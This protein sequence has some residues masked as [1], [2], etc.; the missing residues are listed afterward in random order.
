MEKIEEQILQA[1]DTIVQKRISELQFDKTLKARII[2][3]VDSSGGQYRVGYQDSIL[4]AYSNNALV[5]YDDNT[6]VEI[7]VPLG[8]LSNKKMILRSIDA[9]DYTKGTLTL[10]QYQ[11]IALMAAAKAQETADGQITAFYEETAPDVSAASFGD[12]WIDTLNPPIKYNDYDRIHRLQ[13]IVGGSQGDLDWRDASGS[14]IGQIYLQAYNAQSTADGK[15]KTYYETDP[16]E[17]SAPSLGD[18]WVDVDDKNKLYRYDGTEWIIVQDQSIEESFSL[19]AV[20]DYYYP[21]SIDNVTYLSKFMLKKQ[22]E[23]IVSER[24]EIRAHPFY[25]NLSIAEL[26]SDYESAAFSVLGDVSGDAS[27][28]V[29]GQVGGVDYL[30][31]SYENNLLDVTS[32]VGQVNTSM[33]IYYISRDALKQE[34]QS[35]FINKTQTVEIDSEGLFAGSLV[36]S[37]GVLFTVTNNELSL[38]Y[39]EDSRIEISDS[40][41]IL[42]KSLL[43]ETSLFEGNVYLQSNLYLDN[44]KI[45]KSGNGFNINFEI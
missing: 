28:D 2:E 18:L 41:V 34:F 15:I 35:F 14:A 30:I 42:N 16:T 9:N 31:S 12:I 19:A 32:F 39:G 40:N 21:I 20:P 43:K 38:K 5:S 8:D 26:I 44:L 25:D 13:D 45:E 27:G 10:E 33:S 1:I 23:N 29:T 3:C 36:D 6:M 17:I 11:N 24:D 4:T 37:S 7:L 22:V